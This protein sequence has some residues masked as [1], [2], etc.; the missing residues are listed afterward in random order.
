MG[1]QIRFTAPNK[2]VGY[3]NLLAR[4]TMLGDNAN[5][6]ALA[7]LTVE[8]ERRLMADFQDKRVPTADAPPS[9]ASPE[10]QSPVTSRKSRKAT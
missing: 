8:A 6:V 7:L 2:L 10:K 3:L 4:E 1:S 5:D 9:D